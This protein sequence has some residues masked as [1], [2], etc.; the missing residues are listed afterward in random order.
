MPAITV[1]LVIA[2]SGGYLERIVTSLY[3]TGDKITGYCSPN[4]CIF[5]LLSFDVPSFISNKLF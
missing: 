1:S 4:R 5:E 3:Y 2:V